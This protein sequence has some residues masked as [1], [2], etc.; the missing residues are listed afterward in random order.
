MLA[1]FFNNSFPLFESFQDIGAIDSN[2]ARLTV[3][4]C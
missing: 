2:H 4:P 1:I 3:N